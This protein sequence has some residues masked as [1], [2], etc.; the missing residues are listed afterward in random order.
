MAVLVRCFYDQDYSKEEQQ[1]HP[2]SIQ[3]IDM[4]LSNKKAALVINMVVK[5]AVFC[6]EK[7]RMKSNN[8]SYNNGILFYNIWFY[9]IAIVLLLLLLAAI[10][11]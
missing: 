1:N 4:V 9:S 11:V 2:P 6:F 10:I 7:E 5:A 3:S 8:I